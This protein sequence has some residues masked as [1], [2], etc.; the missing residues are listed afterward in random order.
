MENAS[1]A[2]LLAGGVL[3]MIIVL[4]L[5]TLI[6]NRMGSQTSDFYQKM[7][8][9]S[10][11]EFNQQ[12]FNYHEK[13]K[14]RIQDV[15]TIVNLAKDSNARGIVP[16]EVKVIYNGIQLQNSSS[17]DMISMLSSDMDSEFSCIVKYADKSNYVGE[18][19]ITKN[20]S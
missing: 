13:T 18:V 20:N 2:L 16:V 7:S 1:K 10:I 3:L 4:S 11:D 17:K 9:T 19:R 14:L 8:E 15:V 5:A 6:I 12:F